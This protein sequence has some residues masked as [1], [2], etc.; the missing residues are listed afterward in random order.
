LKSGVQVSSI[1]KGKMKEAGI[2]QD[3]IIT[4]VNNTMVTNPA[5]V[6]AIVKKAKRSVLVEGVY[7][8]GSVFY[9]AIGL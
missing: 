6:A 2:K 8:D 1:E 7:P 9:Y 4:F 5:D 3:F